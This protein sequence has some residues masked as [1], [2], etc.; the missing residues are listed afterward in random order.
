MSQHWDVDFDVEDWL[1]HHY[2]GL[3]RTEDNGTWIAVGKRIGYRPAIL[4]NLSKVRGISY[5]WKVRALLVLLLPMELLPFP[6]KKPGGRYRDIF[7]KQLLG[8]VPQRLQ[9]LKFE[10]LCSLMEALPQS[11]AFDFTSD[12]SI[13]KQL[14]RLNGIVRSYLQTVAD[15][16]AGWPGDHLIQWSQHRYPSLNRLLRKVFKVRRRTLRPPRWLD[17]QRA[18]NCLR[19]QCPG[20]HAAQ[21]PFGTFKGLMH[22]GEWLSDKWRFVAV[23]KMQAMVRRQLAGDED[24][25][26]A[27]E[28]YIHVIEDWIDWPD[29]AANPVD[30]RLAEQLM[31]F[32][33]SLDCPVSRRL[34]IG[35][36]GGYGILSSYS[37]RRDV[38]ELIARHYLIAEPVDEQLYLRMEIAQA[39]V[40]ISQD[41]ELL[42]IARPIVEAEVQA[43]QPTAEQLEARECRLAAE[44]AEDEEDRRI[45][46]LLK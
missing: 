5:R 24:C 11:T 25:V 15:F 14:P 32:L 34:P 41:E 36:L 40:G 31:E 18:F 42:A 10:L 27:F 45:R 43:D 4:K 7:P 6:W 38:V 3:L 28:G 23:R 12:H 9:R 46:D 8:K 33:F 26:G 30:R 13:A 16:R 44:R 20:E 29:G 22:N 1:E 21:E 39:V 17:R 19:L 2:P 37:K 35:L